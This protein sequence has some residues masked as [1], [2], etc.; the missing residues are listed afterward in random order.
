MKKIIALSLCLLL[1]CLTAF[2]EEVPSK[3]AEDLTS[4]EV[5]AENLPEDSDFFVRVVKEDEEGYKKHLEACKAEVEKL[6]EAAGVEEYFGVVTD[7]D[8][9]VVDMKEVLGTDELNVY[10]FVALIAGNYE[11]SYGKVTVKI[12]MPTPYEKDEKVIV[13]IGKV[14][15][16]DEETHEQSVEWTAFEGIGLEP[17]PEAPETPGRIQVEFDPQTVLDIQEGMALAAIVSD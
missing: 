6:K 14:T 5:T 15:V 1:V 4:F 13:L 2:A 3:T 9:N 17:D 16:I 7:I 8:G 10:E 11:E 12:L